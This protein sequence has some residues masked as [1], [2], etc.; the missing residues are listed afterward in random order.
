[1]EVALKLIYE[2][3]I[4]S[5]ELNRKKIVYNNFLLQRLDGEPINIGCE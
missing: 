1:M 3:S 5:I 4:D 2:N